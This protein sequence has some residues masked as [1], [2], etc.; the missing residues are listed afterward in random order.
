MTEMQPRNAP[1]PERVIELA[2]QYAEARVEEEKFRREAVLG[3]VDSI[4][5]WHNVREHR[6][7]LWERYVIEVNE[8]AGQA[9][10][11]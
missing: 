7:Q 11:W 5:H 8:L 1:R 3:V 6:E 9:P 10:L 2:K 4:V